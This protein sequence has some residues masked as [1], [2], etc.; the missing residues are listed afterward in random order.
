MSNLV[1][2]KRCCCQNKWQV[3]EGCCMQNCRQTKRTPIAPNAIVI[4][5]LFFFIFLSEVFNTSTLQAQTNSDSTTNSKLSSENKIITPSKP[6][7]A[8]LS[9]PKS[10]SDAKLAK[11]KLKEELWSKT[12]EAFNNKKYSE[13]ITN[14][15]EC[16]KVDSSEI[17]YWFLKAESIRK[18]HSKVAQK[19]GDHQSTELPVTN[20][21]NSIN[22]L[23]W[24]EECI[25]AYK[26][27]LKLNPTISQVYNNLFVLEAK[28]GRYHEAKKYLLQGASIEPHES[29]KK[30]FH[31]KIL[32][33]NYLTLQKI[34]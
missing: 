18:S 30:Y 12:L 22:S 28:Q 5:I 31:Q 10:V 15:D 24:R 4:L 25:S 26:Q 14:V 2:N 1:E 17:K 19:E 11:I 29:T 16:I 7:R 6:M 20:S 34:I 3:A 33:L 27:V 32:I 23:Q 9:T 13:A 21:D 8:P